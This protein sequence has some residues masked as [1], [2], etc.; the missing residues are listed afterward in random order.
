MSQPTN[1]SRY[2]ANLV[3]RDKLQK[4]LQDEDML[5]KAYPYFLNET[6]IYRFIEMG[7]KV[8]N[9]MLQDLREKII[10][11]LHHIQFEIMLYEMR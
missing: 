6:N 10:R 5:R 11:K 4:A 9:A 7:M 8:S 2:Q 1:D 3:L